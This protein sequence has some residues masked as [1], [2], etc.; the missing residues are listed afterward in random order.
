MSDEM[1]GSVKIF[2]GNFAPVNWLA[3]AGQ[4]EAVADFSPLFSLIGDAFGGDGRSTFGIPDMRGRAPIGAGQ[5]PTLSNRVRGEKGGQ[6]LVQLTVDTIPQHNHGLEIGSDALAA[7]STWEN[8]SLTSTATAH[9]NGSVADSVST[10][11]VGRVAGNS[12]GGTSYADAPGPG[13]GMD[14]TFITVTTT[15]DSMDIK[16]TILTDASK[17]Q[18]DNTG[19]SGAHENM[20]PWICLRYIICWDGY[21]PSRS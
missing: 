8:A 9:P 12:I 11:P 19:Q 21:Y 1:M 2:A 7:S 20:M 16:T 18:I 10:D 17:Y 5:G 13:P 4:L 6:E 3:C 15:L 14:P